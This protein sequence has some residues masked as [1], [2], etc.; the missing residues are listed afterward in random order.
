MT[1]QIIQFPIAARRQPQPIER[2][3]PYDFW[4]ALLE[5]LSP[6]RRKAVI[7]D[8]YRCNVIDERDRGIFLTSWLDM[9][10]L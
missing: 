10:G 9:A 8:A 2:P 1:G 6:A 5:T 7:E 3:E 4:Y